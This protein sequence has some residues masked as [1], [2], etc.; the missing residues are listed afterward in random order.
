MMK[1][2][3]IYFFSLGVVIIRGIY[4]LEIKAE[5]P[6]GNK[7]KWKDRTFKVASDG[8]IIYVFEVNWVLK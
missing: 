5:T 1:H 7:S 4:D 2:T 6:S 8:F 3:C